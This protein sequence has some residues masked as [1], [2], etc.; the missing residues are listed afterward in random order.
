[1]ALELRIAGP[2]LDVSRRLQAGDPALILGRDADCSV[3]LPD[4]ERNVSRR[5]LSVWVEHD[6][7]HFHVL[8]VVN[9]VELSTGELPP[10]ARGVLPVGQLLALAAY[11]LSVSHIPGDDPVDPW[12]ELETQSMPRDAQETIPA[13]G[14]EDDPFGDWGFESTFGPGA[15][16]GPLQ[17][18]ALAP[19]TDIRPFLLGLGMEDTP[20]RPLTQGELETI[21]RL[22]RLALVGLLQALQNAT[23]ARGEMG[24]D[25]RTVV[26]HRETNPLKMD[27]SMEAKLLYLFGGRAPGAHFMA[28][29]RGVAEVVDELLAHHQAMIEASR[30]AVEGT[31][32]EF[33]PERLK[34]RLIGTGAKLFESARAWDAYAKDYEEQKRHLTHWVQQLLDK[35]FADTY[36]REFS[37]L[38]H[39]VPVRRR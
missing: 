3:C 16:G 34:A 29:D 38:K 19:A 18:D 37:R 21:G 20:Q 31:L 30:Q 17:A 10:G 5:H 24:A 27:T 6:Q 15:P 36:A 22:T 33:D 28:P 23:A 26:G 12:T 32:Q 7:L 9:G 25:D 13:T 14:L 35:H 1:M 8:S 4:P 39:G 2:G 11:R